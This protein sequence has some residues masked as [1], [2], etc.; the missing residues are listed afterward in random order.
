MSRL[1]FGV[2]FFSFFLLL[3]VFGSM[4]FAA[5]CALK[6]T[7]PS[8][9]VCT[10]APDA[11]VTDQ[12]SITAGSTD[13]AGVIAMAVYV[14][15]T[16]VRKVS[17]NQISTNRSFAPGKH[18]LVAQLWDHAGRIL[19]CPLYFTVGSSEAPPTVSFLANP[20]SQ[21]GSATLN[22][23]TSN[24]TFV[25]ISNGVGPVPTSGR[26]V[27]F[28]GATST[29][30]LTAAGS[31]GT[32]TATAEVTSPS[33]PTLPG[34]G[35]PCSATDP[36][37]SI[38]I[39]LPTNGSDVSSP[40]RIVAFPNS[41]TGVAAIGVYV[42]NTLA[43]KQS[44][45]SLDTNISM[46]NGS[47]NVVVQ[48]W[49]N[50]GN[51]PAKA[52]V[53]ITV[54]GSSGGTLGVTPQTTNVAPDGTVQF[55]ATE[56]GSAASVTWYVDGIVG[57][58]TAD[59]T[60][61]NNGLY[62]APNTTGS[63]QVKAVLDSDTTQSATSTVNVAAVTQ[64][65]SAIKHIIFVAEENRSFDTYFGKLDEY[66]ASLGLPADVDG[67]P[68]DCSSSNS[69]WT[70]PCGAMNKSPDANGVPTTPIYA[71]H[72]KTMC[73]ENTSADWIVSHWDFNAEA[74]TSDTPMMDGFVISAASAA[75]STGTSD[76]KGIRAMGFYTAQDLAYPYW[77][78]TQFAT[79]DRWFS[80]EAARTQP[81]RYYMVGATSGGQ[82]Y[83]SGVPIQQQT[84][85]DELTA[86]GISWKIYSEDGN[87]SA[88]AYTKF[89]ANGNIVPFSQFIT[90][91]QNGTLPSVA[92]IEKP[93]A[94]EHPGIGVNIQDGVNEVRNL[95]NAVMYGPSWKDSVMIVTFDESG[96]LYD[97]VPPPTN[98]PNPDGIKPLDLCTSSSD[99]GC[100]LASKSHGAPP[101]D[102]A[103]DFTRTGFRV[104]LMVVSPFVKPHYVSH[105]V[106]DYT[107]WMKLVETRFGLPNLNARDAW[108]SDMTEYF[109][110]SAPWATPPQNPPGVNYGSC[111]DSLP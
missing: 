11:L 75:L 41:N 61:D 20:M 85:F 30:T 16:L 68:S 22:W 8:I 58:S 35:A 73:I 34:R 43:Y 42:D 65:L 51:V 37:P 32:T 26:I 17:G 99:P 15:N 56:N 97:H 78:A 103:G 107:S 1:A 77:L 50:G 10:P 82:A 55:S 81:N 24:A 71:F 111:Y 110:F 19:K 100:S 7:N 9:T 108:A 86:K 29:Y 52:S 106:T 12:V 101:Y 57:G 45:Q 98:V 91:A 4:A 18:Y 88:T 25:S 95:V 6:T 31:N 69:D 62:T 23:S 89:R 76:T 72:L 36:A 63:H 59:G 67:L 33:R 47:H 96:G 49:D 66:R 44:V 46:T 109:D 94:D 102:P 28:P 90:D 84:I 74:P 2:R 93:N 83:P 80:P 54:N 13:S 87:S 27:V 64:D 79:S 105:T 104:P 3:A 92:Y 40:A 70:T 5:P 60:I 53:N 21:D 48:F 14:D 38:N 39:C